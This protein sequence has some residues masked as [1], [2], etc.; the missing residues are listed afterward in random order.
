ML[1]RMAV[2]MEASSRC[3]FRDCTRA[4]CRKRLCGMTVAPMMPMAMTSMPLSRKPGCSRAWPISRKLRL[5]LRQHE[6]LDAIANADRRHQDRHDRLQHAHAHALQRQ[7]Q[8][9]VERGDDDRPRRAGCGRGGSAPPR[10]PAIRPGRWRPPRV[11]SQSSWA[12]GSISEYQS[13][14]AL[15]EVFAG[16]DAEAGG[17]DLEDHRHEAGQR[18]DPQQ[19]VFELGPGG[20]VGAPVAGVHVAHADQDRRP[21]ECAPFPPEAGGVRRHRDGA[22]DAFQ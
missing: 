14:Q 2:R 20:E 11:P 5:R 22:V 4:E 10:C 3:S 7:Q 15:R 19:A 9:H 1:K 21:D 8:Q 18:D 6:D 12:S 17:D 16:G 13:R